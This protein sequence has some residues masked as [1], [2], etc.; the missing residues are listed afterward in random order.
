VLLS[1]GMNPKFVQELLG[2][3]DIRLTL[4]TYSHY[5]LSMGDQTADAMQSALG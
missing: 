4:G 3:A 2:H 5:L 1:K